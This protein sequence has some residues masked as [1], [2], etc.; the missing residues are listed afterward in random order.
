MLGKNPRNMK[1]KSALP[2]GSNIKTGLH[3]QG[4]PNQI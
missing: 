1:K 3:F 4:F 2:A